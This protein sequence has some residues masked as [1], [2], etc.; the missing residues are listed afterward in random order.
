ML[1]VTYHFISYH[2]LKDVRLF[3]SI[4]FWEQRLE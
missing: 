4:R 3:A 1:A 2:V